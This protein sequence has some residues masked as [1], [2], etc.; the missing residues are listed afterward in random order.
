LAL[1][2]A[3]LI[4]L[5]HGLTANLIP[6]YSIGVFVPFTLAQVGMVVKWKRDFGWVKGFVRAIPN[7][8]GAIICLLIVLILV[9][10]RLDDIW[11]FFLIMPLI[12]LFFHYVH[13]HYEMIARQLKITPRKKRKNYRGNSVIVLIGNVT[14]ADQ[15]AVDY[16]R[17]IGSEV[18]AVHIDTGEN[19]SKDAEVHLEFQKFFPD[20]KLKVIRSTNRS[21]TRPIINYIKEKA[22]KNKKDKLTTTVLIP[23]FVPKHSWQKIL[24]NQTAAKIKLGLSQNEN[25][26]LSNYSYHLKK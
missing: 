5:F 12:L 25:I 14:I 21:I 13:Q 22:A 19:K 4:V 2:A 7:I 26:I 1:G 10:F 8:I 23:Q 15:G 16:A 17:S 18:I 3:L 9:I 6:L 20:V 24:H 11:P